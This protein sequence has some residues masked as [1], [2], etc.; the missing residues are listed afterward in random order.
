MNILHCH[1]FF[2]FLYPYGKMLNKE[3]VNG[4][5]MSI[6]PPKIVYMSRRACLFGG[7]MA[8]KPTCPLIYVNLVATWKDA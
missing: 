6:W 1:V 5:Y 4:C 7:H 8:A 2:N 3:N